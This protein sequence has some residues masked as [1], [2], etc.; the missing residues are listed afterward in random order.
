MKVHNPGPINEKLSA[1]LCGRC[2]QLGVTIVA[3]LRGLGE[4]RCWCEPACAALDG[5]PFIKSRRRTPRRR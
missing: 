5:W 3:I 4:I 2:G 1:M